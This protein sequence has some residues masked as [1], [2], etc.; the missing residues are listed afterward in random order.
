MLCVRCGCLYND[1]SA[2]K[3]AL[4]LCLHSPLVLRPPHGRLAI[5]KYNS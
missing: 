2:L 3:E 1:G 4:T 5:P